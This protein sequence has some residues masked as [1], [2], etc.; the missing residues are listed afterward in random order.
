M[1]FA[2]TE[3]QEALRRTARRFLG[4]HSTSSQ[5]RAAMAIRLN[6]L[7]LGCTGIQPAIARRYAEMLNAGIHPVV[8]ATTGLPG[9]SA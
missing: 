3:E 8:P 9:I 4:S 6:C 7:L 5:V 2:F 1:H